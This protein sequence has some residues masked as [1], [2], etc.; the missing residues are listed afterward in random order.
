MPAPLP[1]NETERLDALRGYAVLD[2]Q[3]EQAYDD[4]TRLAAF[5][6]GTPIAL[7][8]LVDEDRQ[9]FKSRVGLQA[10]QTPREDSFCAHA[11][12]QPDDVLVVEDASKDPRFS[13]NPLVTGTPGIR[14]Y[15]GAPM[16][17]DSGAAL[18]SV[19]VIDRV[20]R[21]MEPVKLE[22]LK[23]LS[24]LV[25]AQLE[26]RHS[27]R[28]QQLLSAAMRRQQT[29]LSQYQLQLEAANA[30]LAALSLLDGLTGLKNRR[31]FD[32]FMN[33]ESSRTE[34]SHVPFALLMI[35]VDHFKS[36][37]DELGHVTGDA[38]LQKI[39]SLIQS[40]ARTYDLAARYGGEEFA[41]VLPDTGIVEAMTV[42]ERIRKA[43]PQAGW[44]H[45]APTVSIGVAVTA[46][47]QSSMTIL[48]R[49]DRALFQAKR[50]GRN[51]VVS[52][53]AEAER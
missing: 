17:T 44:H 10:S 51:C 5:I 28:E 43:V 13:E 6:C 16:V 1:P 45:R 7:I 2:S 24:R 31:S 37:N 33:T 9:W 19:C 8:S 12:L 41:L 40:Q 21:K 29:Q 14:F 42:A 38:I 22:A 25:V 53:S 3:A 30:E 48:E 11:I 36:F 50:K 26:L 46:S 32:N 20:P 49:A 18:G 4:I 35:D 23:A 39:A 52:Q 27:L 34:R 15:A 47:A